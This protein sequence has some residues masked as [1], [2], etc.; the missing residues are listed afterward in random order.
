M[1]WHNGVTTAT[2]M[3]EA[4][5]AVVEISLLAKQIEGLQVGWP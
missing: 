3:F 1:P 5:M 4:A 2:T